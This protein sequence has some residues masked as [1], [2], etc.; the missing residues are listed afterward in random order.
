MERHKVEGGAT[1]EMPEAS[2]HSLGGDD[3]PEPGA[4]ELAARMQELEARA[5]RYLANW[6]RAQADLQNYRKQVER[7]QAELV[8]WASA[9]LMEQTLPVLDDM[10]RAFGAIPAN[11]LSLTWIEGVWLVYKKL[12]A[13]LVSRGLEGVEVEPGQQFDPRLHQ[14]LAEVAGEAGTVVESVQRGYTVGGRLLRPALVTIGD[15]SVS[16]STG[17]E[18]SSDATAADAEGHAEN[19]ASASAG[20]DEGGAAAGPASREGPSA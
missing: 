6:Q 8:Q 1:D 13:L 12:E 15:G 7:D 9:A 20:T 14:A 3:A 19:A 18:S 16:P 17:T 5:Q 2:N 4:E 10:E 11:L